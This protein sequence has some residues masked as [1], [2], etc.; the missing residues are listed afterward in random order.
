MMTYPDN[1]TDSY[2]PTISAAVNF[3]V[4]PSLDL[5]PV[6]EEVGMETYNTLA[7]SWGVVDLPGVTPDLQANANNYGEHYDH[8]LVD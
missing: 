4:Y 8:H 2:Y 5:T 1:N 7:N 3:N 6:A